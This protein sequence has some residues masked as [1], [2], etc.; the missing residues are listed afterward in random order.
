MKIRLHEME[1]G[2]EDVQQRTSLL[3]SIL[4]LQPKLEQQAL[5]VLDAG[6]PGFD[7]NVST[8]FPAGAIALRFLTDDLP[9]VEERLKAAAIPYEGPQPS[10]LG[11]QCLV[12]RLAS[13][14]VIH[15][16]TPGSDSPAWLTV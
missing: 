10:H 2:T 6:L 15:I 7:L 14:C 8:H 4:G 5:T 16:N 13:G 3:Q 11:M 1:L 12:F 9:A